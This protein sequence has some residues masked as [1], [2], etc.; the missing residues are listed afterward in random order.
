MLITYILGCTLA[1]FGSACLANWILDHRDR[2]RP[3]N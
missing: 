2:R 1:F 3:K